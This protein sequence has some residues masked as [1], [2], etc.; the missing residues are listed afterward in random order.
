MREGTSSGFDKKNIEGRKNKVTRNL[1]SSIIKKCNG[2]EIIKH[3]LAR[4][5]KMKFTPINIIYEPIYDGN[6]PVPC[7][8]TN[9]IHLA[10]R[11]YIGKYLKGQEKIRHPIVRKRLYCEKCFCKNEENMKHHIKMCA[12]KEGITYCFD[13]GNT[14]FFQ[15]NFKYLG[16]VPFTVYFGFEKVQ[17]MLFFFIQ[18]CLL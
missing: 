16:D 17:V 9:E 15:D 14:I 1:T 4:K 2:Y 7:Y 11:S 12:A 13:N 5:E 8:F 10:Y 3:E 6:V 18:K